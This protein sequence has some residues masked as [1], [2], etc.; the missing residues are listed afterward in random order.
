M[1]ENLNLVKILDGC[2]V[3]I[4][5]YHSTYGD[6]QFVCL[7][8]G[9]VYPITMRTNKDAITSLT[10]DGRC[11][12]DYDGEC[13]LFPSKY[14]RD[15]SKFERFWDK[16]KI[17]KFDPKT[18][19]VFD[20]VLVRIGTNYN[21]GEWHI[22]FFEYDVYNII[23]D[24]LQDLKKMASTITLSDNEYYTYR[25]RP[26]LLADYV[27]GNGELYFIILMLNDI[28]SVKDFDTR[29]VK[30][31]SKSD[32]SNALSSINASEKTFIDTYN[33]SAK[34]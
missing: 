4:V 24:Y 30:L 7:N 3:G 16:P 1:N 32:L 18:F 15:W 33:E 19:Q 17:K 29:T 31:I 5:F 22:D 8:P 6:V 28:W 20:E 27:Y 9:S 23:S 13:Q 2:P 14:Q 34:S 26:K 11:D 21:S 12:Y 25:F 10:R